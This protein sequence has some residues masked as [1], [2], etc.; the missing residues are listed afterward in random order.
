MSPP[1]KIKSQRSDAVNAPFEARAAYI[2]FH[3]KKTKSAAG[4]LYADNDGNPTPRHATTL[5]IPKT[6]DASTCKNYAFLWGLAC[7]AGMKMWPTSVNDS[8]TWQWP[9]GAKFPVN[10]G[11]VPFVQKPVPGKP[12]L[13]EAERIEKNKWRNGCWTLDVESRSDVGV[14]KVID[15]F[16]Y[17][18]PAQ[19]ARLVN[20]Q[21]LGDPAAPEIY[22][23]G[24]WGIP[25]IHAY[26]YQNKTFG[27]NF[28][29][30]G[31]LFT[32]EGEAIGNGGGGGPRNTSQMFGGLGF[33][34]AAPVTTAPAAAAAPQA[35][36]AT[37]TAPVAAPT[38]PP[39]G[40]PGLPP[41]PPPA[42]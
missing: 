9:P 22:K 19:R 8:A 16:I 11:D 25:N 15:G 2:Y 12:I 39:A 3:T 7:Q 32:R 18:V 5:L 14:A 6:G 10:D 38:A 42:R 13:S 4:E 29:F 30:D 20:G 24:D 23:S 34:T 35:P 41:P 27:V 26:A 40:L 17:E 21:V 37:Y 33:S 36:A 1:T 28:G 31:F